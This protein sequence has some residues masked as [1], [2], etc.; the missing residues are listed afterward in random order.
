MAEKLTIEELQK[1]Q[2]DILQNRLKEIKELLRY[3][4]KKLPDKECDLIIWDANMS[5]YLI[6]LKPLPKE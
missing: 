4:I 2:I 6:I 1:K 3:S 5:A